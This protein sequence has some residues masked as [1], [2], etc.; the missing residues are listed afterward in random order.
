MLLPSQRVGF[1]R[2]FVGKPSE[3]TLQMECIELCPLD[4][5]I[6]FVVKTMRRVVPVHAG[7]GCG[8]LSPGAWKYSAAY[9]TQS[10]TL[11]TQH[12]D[13]AEPYSSVIPEK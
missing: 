13:T 7:E 10:H 12:M 3:S 1:E 6:P 5:G 11:P 9:A 8:H 2:G 4:Y